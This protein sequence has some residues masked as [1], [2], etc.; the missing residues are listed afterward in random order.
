[1][2]DYIKHKWLHIT[3]KYFNHT[4]KFLCVKNKYFYD[5]YECIKCNHFED[6][7][8]EKNYWMKSDCEIK[9]FEINKC[10]NASEYRKMLPHELGHLYDWTRTDTYKAHPR[11]PT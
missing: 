2:I 9:V 1:M 11:R 7:E 5:K 6:F 3:N 8:D 4:Y 10:I